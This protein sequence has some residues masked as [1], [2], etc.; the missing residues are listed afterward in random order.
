MNSRCPFIKDEDLMPC[1]AP[2]EVMSNF[3]KAHTMYY[4]SRSNEELLE[5]FS[6]SVRDCLCITPEKKIGV[7][8][9]KKVWARFTNLFNELISRGYQPEEVMRSVRYTQDTKGIFDEI[10]AAVGH[11]PKWKKFEKLVNAI[12]AMRSEGAQII[13]DDK[14]V[15]KRTG[16]ERQIDISLRFDHSYYSYFVVIECKDYSSAVPISEV[17]AFRTK[18]E[19]VGADKGVMVSSNGFQRGTIETAKAYNIDLF[20]LS[21][22]HSAWVGRLREYAVT[23][24]FP[25]DITFDHLPVPED[26]RGSTPNSVGFTEIL[27]YKDTSTPPRNLADILGDVCLWALNTRLR[28]PA[29][30]DLRFDDQYLMKLP[31]C[32][33]YIPVYGMTLILVEYRYAKV[34]KVDIPPKLLRYK[35]TDIVRAIVHTVPLSDSGER[36]G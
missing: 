20:T 3:C 5:E 1:G 24:P 16:R 7:I 19:D 28:L 25:R 35:Y 30:V 36:K 2:K 11:N 9:D 26:G 18:L 34:K 32:S 13:Y 33:A 21:E 17:E 15:G 22:E 31:G 12:H 6:H 14:V 29:K 4:E 10:F 8:P 23:L 27:F